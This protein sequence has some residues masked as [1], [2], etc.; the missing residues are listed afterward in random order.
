MTEEKKKELR[1][2]VDALMDPID[3]GETEESLK[4]Q[5]AAET[6]VL[7]KSGLHP[8]M[9]LLPEEGEL[10]ACPY[11]KNE[12]GMHMNDLRVEVDIGDGDGVEEFHFPEFERGAGPIHEVKAGKVSRENPMSCRGARLSLR[13]WCDCCGTATRLTLG[14]H[15]GSVQSALE[16]EGLYKR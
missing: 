8:L 2:R 4:K 12:F 11:C 10:L 3:W 13:F 15:K 16:F 6:E 5:T 14:F 1:A 7:R 9:H